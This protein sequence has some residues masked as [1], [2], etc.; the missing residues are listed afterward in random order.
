VS[1]GIK[2]WFDRNPPEE[3]DDMQTTRNNAAALT[4]VPATA[5]RWTDVEE[6]LGV[7]G[8][9]GCW[10]QAWRGFDAK[11][12]SGGRSREELLREQLAGGAPSP[13]YL[14]YLDGLPVGWIGVSNL[15]RHL[16]RLDL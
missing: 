9:P 3:V 5:Q 6:L 16:V 8:E 4:I 10:C 11:A 1:N 14:A 2:P 15:P 13:G 7:S 12:I